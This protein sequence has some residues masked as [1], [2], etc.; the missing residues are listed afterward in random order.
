MWVLFWLVACTQNAS[1]VGTV[2]PL[3]AFDTHRGMMTHGACVGAYQCTVGASCTDGQ[4]LVTSGHPTCD[5]AIIVTSDTTY[6]APTGIAF[7]GPP[8]NVPRVVC[9]VQND[10][11]DPTWH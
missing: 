10:R 9:V 4:W 7:V 8:C 6:S 3:T 5:T 11:E 2:E 1:T